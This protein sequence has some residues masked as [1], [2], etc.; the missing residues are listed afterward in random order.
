MRGV[1]PKKQKAR[2]TDRASYVFRRMRQTV[3]GGGGEPDEGI[4]WAVTAESR[5]RFCQ[6]G[7]SYFFTG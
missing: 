5:S 3:Q 1:I 7:F 4:A 6:L 2:S